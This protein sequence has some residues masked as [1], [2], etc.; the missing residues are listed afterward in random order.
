M[1]YHRVRND[2]LSIKNLEQANRLAHKYDPEHKTI[3][4]LPGG[5]GSILKRTTKRFDKPSPVSFKYDDVW[6]DI[7]IFPPKKEA[8]K[9]KI[10]SNGHDKGSH[11]IRAEGALDY[12]IVVYDGTKK[13]F[14]LRDYNY[15]EYGFDWRRPLKECAKLLKEFLE[16]FRD[17][18]EARGLDNPLSQT[19]LI[20]HSH[21]G[22]VA[23][24]Y[25]QNIFQGLNPT[26]G[27]VSKWIDKV[28]TVGTPFYA[29][30]GHIKRYYEGEK[31]LHL[32][33]YD[34]RELAK[35]MSSMSGPYIFMYLDRETYNRDGAKLGLTEYPMVDS[36]DPNVEVDPYDPSSFSRFPRWINTQYIKDAKKSR[37]EFTKKLSE[38]VRDRIYHI[39]GVKENK[40]PVKLRW[41]DIDGSTYNP[42][43]DKVPIRVKKEDRG[44]G[45]G[46]VPAWAARLAQ[47]DD[48]RVY[49]LKKAKNHMDLMEH[50]ETLD[51]I[52]FVVENDR[53][54]KYMSVKNKKFLGVKSASDGTLEKFVSNL[55]KGTIKITDK[56]ASDPK[57]WRAIINGM[58]T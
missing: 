15:F 30:S 32:L 20:C 46:T 42:K 29:N 58:S 54:P 17:L 43:K 24:Q 16:E 8:Y 31:Q 22:L 44:P 21:G 4:L 19:T 34:K 51:V 41:K 45:D 36:S 33:L 48:E 47:V 37:E 12:L 2:E 6:I 1:E 3:I 56:E 9:L 53:L 14:R 7:D 23:T 57:I 28:I 26:P 10:D 39:R 11:I 25:L 49:D 27:A 52:R 35:T 5:G 18:V 55:D 13:Y 38:A 40:T 50:E